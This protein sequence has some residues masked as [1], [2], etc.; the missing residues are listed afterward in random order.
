M[1]KYHEQKN[2]LLI[3]ADD[4]HL[5]IFDLVSKEIALDFKPFKKDYESGVTSIT[6]D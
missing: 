1:V 3:G 5:R 4:C 6:V 2:A